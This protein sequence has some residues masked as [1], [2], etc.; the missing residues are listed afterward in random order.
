MIRFPLII[1]ALLVFSLHADATDRRLELLEQRISELESQLDGNDV[2]MDEL[3]LIVEKVERKSFTD[4]LNFTPEVRLRFDEM[5]Y[6]VGDF[7]TAHDPSASTQSRENIDKDFDIASSV[8]FRLNMNAEIMNELQFH[9]R[10]VFQH[11]TQSNERLCILS[12]EIKSSG[13]ISG[14]DID[15]AYFDYLL[16]KG[17]DYPMIFSFG[18]LPTSG[19]TPMQFAEVRAR[20]SVFP[21]LVFDMDSYGVI[22]TSNLSKLLLRESFV[23]LVIAQAYTLDP[24]IYPYQCNRE[25]IDNADIYG[26]YLDSYI[27]KNMLFSFGIN[28]LGNL[29]AHP[30]LGPDVSAEN[31]ND[32]GS[33][34]TV[35]LGIDATKVVGT[36]L[37]A[38]FHIAASHGHSNGDIDDYSSSSDVNFTLSD[39]STGEIITDVGYSVYIGGLYDLSSSVTLGVEY[40]HG[41]KYWFAATQGA[42][43]MYNKLATRGDVGEL[44]AIWKLNRYLFTKAGYMY[45]QEDYT[46]SG[47]HFG[48]PIPKGGKQQ[49]GYIQINASF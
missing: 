23:R 26:L 5:R 1:V 32:L 22:F 10:F 28:V 46:G 27:V 15:R 35:G 25:T 8:R 29:K 36:D 16:N 6:K 19:G 18:V 7:E 44:Y 40:N 42:E 41:S 31:S 14:F 4:L 45:T 34:V 21:A 43:D 37:T 20:Q 30:Y 49:V 12:Q 33:M 9:G 38:F 11:S 2:N 3:V 17:S 47:W 13:S 48:E 24:N 39:Y